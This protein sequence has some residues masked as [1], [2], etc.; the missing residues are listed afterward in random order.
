MSPQVFNRTDL[1]TGAKF[2]A[3][4]ALIFSLIRF[5]VFPYIDFYLLK[6]YTAHVSGII[7]SVTGNFAFVSGEPNPVI[8]FPAG[9]AEIIDLCSGSLELL[10]M[11]AIIFATWDAPLK[12]RVYGFLMGTAFILLVNPVRIAVTLLFAVYGGWSFADL[13]HGILFKL[14]L[15][16]VI[17]GFYYIWYYRFMVKI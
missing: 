4:I 14:A 6:L 12:K 2:M 16:I 3:G 9:Q 7:L 8:T 13:V 1:V 17:A 11:A 5:G 15:L 10:I